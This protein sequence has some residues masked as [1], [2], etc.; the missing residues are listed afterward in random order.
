MNLLFLNLVWEEASRTEKLEKQYDYTFP[1]LQ[2][3]GK[4]NG[5]PDIRCSV[6]PITG[7]LTM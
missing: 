1:T 5:F 6:P 7:T 4:L 2:V 3:T